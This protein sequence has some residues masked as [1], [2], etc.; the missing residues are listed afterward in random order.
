MT[1]ATRVWPLPG[2]IFA[3][4]IAAA[5]IVD[6]DAVDRL[7]GQMADEHRRHVDAEQCVVH[8]VQR[9]VADDQAVDALVADLAQIFAAM[10][11]RV[12]ARHV[13]V[14]DQRVEADRLE[15]ATARSSTSS[16]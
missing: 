3:H 6:L 4:Q 7:V 9:E 11:L 14:E 1:W 2:E 15:F 16:G 5:E 13:G 10:L 8:A 12:A